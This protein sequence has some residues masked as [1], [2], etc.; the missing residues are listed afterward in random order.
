[1]SGLETLI[2][3]LRDAGFPLIL[4]WLLTLSVVYGILSHISVPKSLSAR[5][6]IAI[7][8]AFMVLFAAAANEATT[9]IQNLVV[10]GIV[11]A[12]A[13]LIIMIFLELTGTKAGGEH[14]FAKHPKQFGIAIIVLVL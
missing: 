12:F 2:I 9:F 14:I 7:V 3:S 10:S 11:I 1:M 13:L 8:A 4:L 5:G 6:V